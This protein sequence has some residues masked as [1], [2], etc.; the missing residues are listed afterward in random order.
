M[1]EP[2]STE[3]MTK[4]DTLRLKALARDAIAAAL[5]DMR[6]EMHVPPPSETSE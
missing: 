6:E 5:A 4:K 2:I 3:G 1:L